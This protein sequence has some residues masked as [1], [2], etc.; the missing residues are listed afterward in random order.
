MIPLRSPFVLQNLAGQCQ[1]FL[2]CFVQALLVVLVVNGFHSPVASLGVRQTQPDEGVPRD[3][4]LGVG[5]TW[6]LQALVQKLNHLALEQHRA[7]AQGLEAS[8]EKAS[9]AVVQLRQFLGLQP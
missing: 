9:E 3:G 4:L 6:V 2:R 8:D 7:L 5:Q 1:L